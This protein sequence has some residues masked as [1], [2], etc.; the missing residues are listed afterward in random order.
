MVRSTGATSRSY[1]ACR[2]PSHM[3]MEVEEGVAHL[4]I[5]LFSDICVHPSESNK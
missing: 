2:S 5:V 3:P 1:K 4:V